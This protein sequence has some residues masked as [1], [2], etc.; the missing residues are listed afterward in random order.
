MAARRAEADEFYAELTPREATADE[1]MV[2][3]QGFAGLLWSKQLFY[4]DV[5]RRL[6]GDPGQPAAPS[7]G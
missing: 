4:Y 3:R 1:A 2:M 6:D 5:A 7:S